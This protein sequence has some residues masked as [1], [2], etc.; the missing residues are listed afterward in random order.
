MKMTC[1]LAY[2]LSEPEHSNAANICATLI[3]QLQAIVF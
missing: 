2:G 1:D 3:F